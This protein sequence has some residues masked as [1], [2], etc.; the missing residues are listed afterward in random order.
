MH[1]RK[2]SLY[3]QLPLSYS[4]HMVFSQENKFTVFGGIAGDSTSSLSLAQ[5]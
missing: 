3:T 2:G 5:G 1:D 4:Q